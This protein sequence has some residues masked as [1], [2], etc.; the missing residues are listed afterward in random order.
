MTLSEVLTIL[1]A[2]HQ[3]NRTCLT[4]FYLDLCARDRHLFPTLVSYPRFVTLIKQAFPALLCLL[5][6][7]QG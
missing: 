2:Y 1:I 7:V 5:K 4:Y 3:S 6:S